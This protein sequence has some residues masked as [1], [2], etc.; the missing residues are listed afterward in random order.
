MT[1]DPQIRYNSNYAS[2]LE[3][4]TVLVEIYLSTATLYFSND[5]RSIIKNGGGIPGSGRPYMGQIKSISPVIHQYDRDFTGDPIESEIEIVIINDDGNGTKLNVYLPGGGSAATWEGSRVLARGLNDPDNENIDT[6]FLLFEG[7]IRKNDGIDWNDEEIKIRVVDPRRGQERYVAD[8]KYERKSHPRA[9]ESLYGQEIQWV[10]GDYTDEFLVPAQVIDSAGST[11]IP[12]YLTLQVAKNAVILPSTTK[13]VLIMRGNGAILANAIAEG[14]VDGQIKLDTTT[15]LGYRDTYPIGID[16]V[17]RKKG[18]YPVFKGL[19]RY[20]YSNDF[21]PQEQDRFYVKCYGL[22]NIYDTTQPAKYPGEIIAALLNYIGLDPLAFYAA[23]AFDDSLEGEFECRRI[24]NSKTSIS[25]LIESLFLEIMAVGGP[26]S[27]YRGADHFVWNPQTFN[28]N[29]SANKRFLDSDILRDGFDSKIN[30]N[31]SHI[32]QII[33]EFNY[34]DKENRFR[35]SRQLENLTDQITFGVL[36]QTRQFNWLR[37][38]NDVEASIRRYFWIKTQ[39]LRDVKIKNWLG[40]LKKLGDYDAVT[41]SDLS[42][43]ICQWYKIE[44]EPMTTVVSLSGIQFIDTKSIG[45]WKNISGLSTTA[46]S[47]LTTDLPGWWMGSPDILTFPQNPQ[48]YPNDEIQIREGAGFLTAAIVTTGINMSQTAF[49]NALKAALDLAGA[50]T[51]TV[52]RSAGKWQIT[53]TGAWSLTFASITSLKCLRLFAQM[54][55]NIAADHSSSGGNNLI[56]ADYAV[57]YVGFS[58]TP[59]SEFY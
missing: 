1:F 24:I 4:Y 39:K 19:L 45:Y 32:N 53:S 34:S 7:Y 51:Y 25:E 47:P 8:V 9:S 49:Q 14:S 21:A 36:T 27:E 59:L 17:Q 37:H 6:S 28:P 31:P 35:G 3:T 22:P 13:N 15:L 41:F 43:A 2:Y 18:G 50:N 12:G 56:E 16:F 42:E 10:F 38:H 55:F 52:A 5:T 40:L 20:H 30:K 58:D 57:P 44:K 46:W 11:A 54:G 48:G 33:Y 26:I 23:S 29:P